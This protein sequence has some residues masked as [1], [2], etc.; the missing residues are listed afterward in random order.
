MTASAT[1]SECG[2]PAAGDEHLP[3][4]QRT[5]C[6]GCGSRSRDFAISVVALIAPASLE[7]EADL[8]RGP[9]PRPWT[10]AWAIL[11]HDYQE[12]EAVLSAR[13]PKADQYQLESTCNTFFERCFHLKDYLKNDPQVLQTVRDNVENFLAGDIALALCRDIANTVKH[14]DRRGGK[15]YVRIGEFL[16]GPKLILHATDASG[17]TTKHDALDIARD[18]MA[19]WRT[20]LSRHGM[21]A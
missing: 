20:F 8:L 21:N 14:R 7:V 1:C 4:D 12:L 11:Q 10:E 5:P 16:F 17:S 3:V 9:G 2:L 15:R 18:A 13:N 19:A 6:T